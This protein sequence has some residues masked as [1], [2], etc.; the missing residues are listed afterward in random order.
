MANEFCINIGLAKRNWQAAHLRLIPLVSLVFLVFLVWMFTN[1]AVCFR[2]T[3]THT[4]T[5]LLQVDSFV[6]SIELFSGSFLPRI[7]S[8]SNLVRFISF[9]VSSLLFFVSW[10]EV[11]RENYHDRQATVAPVFFFWIATTVT[12]TI[13]S[14]SISRWIII[15]IMVWFASIRYVLLVF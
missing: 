15:L 5:N 1:P 8:G 2:H 7:V 4:H 3:H 12:W 13:T 9:V 11:R 6:V 14:K 10:R